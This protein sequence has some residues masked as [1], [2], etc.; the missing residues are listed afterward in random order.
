MKE[1]CGLC[2]E[3]VFYVETGLCGEC[4]NRVTLAIKKGKGKE[5]DQV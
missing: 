5:S 1:I 3:P 2:D 4:D